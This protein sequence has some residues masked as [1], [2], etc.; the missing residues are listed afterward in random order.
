MKSNYRKIG[1]LIRLVDERNV[2]L[3]VTTLLWLS[4]S[5]EFIPSVANIIGT[6]MENYKIIRK[7]QFACSLMQVRRDKKIPV[8][9]LLNREEAIISQA[10]P[11]FEVKDK[12]ILLPEYLMMWFSRE[13]F[14]RESCFYAVG[15]VRW[16]LEWSDFCDM[17]LPIPSIEQQ[18]EIIAEY[19]VLINRI[20]LGNTLIEKLEDTAQSLYKQWFV[21]FEFPDA[22][23][24]PYK[25]SGGEL[26]ES[27][28]GEIPKGWKVKKISDVVLSN[29]AT[30]SQKNKFLTIEYLDTSS[31]INNEI[32]EVQNLNLS[33]DE[34]PSRAKRL[35][36]NNNIIFSTVRPNL[37]HFWIVKNPKVNM[38][39]STG[40]LVLKMN[41]PNLGSEL[42]YL[43][44]TSDEC[45]QNFQAIA[46]MSVS[47]YPSITPEDILNINFVLPSDDFLIVSKKLIGSQF[48]LLDNFQNEKRVLRSMNNLLLS[49]LATITL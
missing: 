15:W 28:M 21:D 32:T 45:L 1:E 22:D 49:K 44:I 46:E 33:F 47:T 10:Y 18:K 9:L 14:D 41:Y 29:Y 17:E 27:E 19:G 43:L 48:E 42:I 6:D 35:V 38:V 24:N 16:S 39:V 34:I 30:L 2:G 40:F 26:I 36:E 12:D 13:E 11:V 37:K 5:K 23:G 3:K 31:I 20:N 7:Y 8:A 25:S 4:I